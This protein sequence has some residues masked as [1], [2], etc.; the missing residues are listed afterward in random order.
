FD[1]R[2]HPETVAAAD[3]YYVPRACAQCH[4]GLTNQFRAKVNFLDTDHWVDRVAPAYGLGD[5]K[6]SREDFTA[7]GQTNGVI[8]DGRGGSG[9]LARA[10][11]VIWKLNKEIEAQNTEV[12]E[13]PDPGHPDNFAVR[14]VSKWLALHDPQVGDPTR[15]V[16]PYERG[17]GVQR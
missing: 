16:P 4:G 10:F 8:F 9:Y 11:D 17:F 6:F 5:S 15:H 12:I 13:D 14:A 1:G 2:R 7:L 3:N